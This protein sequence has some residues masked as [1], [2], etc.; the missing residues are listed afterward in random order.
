MKCA[1]DYGLW[2]RP[3]HRTQKLI[4]QFQKAQVHIKKHFTNDNVAG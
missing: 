4:I 3:N 2:K 1:I